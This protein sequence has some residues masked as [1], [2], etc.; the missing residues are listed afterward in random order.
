MGL[1]DRDYM[2]EE[3]SRFRRIR[4]DPWSPT[5]ALLVLLAVIYLIQWVMNL[6]GSTWIETHLGLS[7]NGLRQGEYWQLFTF[8]F[9]HGSWLHLILNGIGLY[10]CGRAV[11]AILGGKRL[12][13]L[14]FLSGTCGGL[15]QI[16]TSLLLQQNP[17]TPVVGASAGIS[18]LLAAFIMCQPDARLIVFPIP[19]PLRAWT[20]LWI[21]L[22][23]SIFGTVF[24]F[25]GV[26]HAA[27]LGGLLTGGAFIRWNWRKRRQPAEPDWLVPPKLKKSAAVEP[28]HSPKVGDDDEVNAIL[29]KIN[30]QGIHSLTNRERAILDRARARLNQR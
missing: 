4:P 9:L 20:L 28:P 7:L 11:Q 18:G 10:S 6:K 13:L 22:A 16:I 12:L 25:G 23:V 30:A 29:E 26:A 15:L 17:Y 24:P 21:V 1:Y 2:R 27:H 8:Q 3:E 5:V 19:V 14:Y